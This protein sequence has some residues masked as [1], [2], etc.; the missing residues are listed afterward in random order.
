MAWDGRITLTTNTN[1]EDEIEKWNFKNQNDNYPKL[2]NAF[3]S[4]Q[5]V[6]ILILDVKFHFLKISLSCYIYLIL[7]TAMFE[8]V[9][10]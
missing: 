1:F 9:N 8:S 10:K 5:I 4:F 2:T 6:L 7:I 3:E